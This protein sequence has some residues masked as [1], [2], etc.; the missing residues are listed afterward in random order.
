MDGTRMV[1]RRQTKSVAVAETADN[2]EH[3]H[4]AVDRAKE[5]CYNTFKGRTLIRLSPHNVR[6]II[7]TMSQC[8]KRQVTKFWQFIC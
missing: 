3:S 7:F 5:V 2:G 8:G 4:G 6:N 1:R